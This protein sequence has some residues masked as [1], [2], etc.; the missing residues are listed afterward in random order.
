MEIKNDIKQDLCQELRNLM[1][2]WDVLGVT[3]AATERD[4]LRLK[5]RINEVCSILDG[6]S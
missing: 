2:Q 1:S 3:K 6:L 5:G 4:Y